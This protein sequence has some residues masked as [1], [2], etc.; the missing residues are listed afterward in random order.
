MAD[1][2]AGGA[3]VPSSSYAISPSSLSFDGEAPSSHVINFTGVTL[4]ASSNL[5]RGTSIAPTRAS[6]W[7]SFSGTVTATPAQVYTDYRE[8]HT[9]GAAEV[10]GIGSFPFMD[11]GASCKS[12]FA[13]QAI[14]QVDAGSTVLSAAGDPAIGIFPIW[15]KLLLNGETFTSGGVAA[16]AFLSV[17]A[18]VTDVSGEN[19]SVFNIEQASGVIKDIFYFRATS[20]SW[21]NFFTFAAEQ[22]PI[23]AW[24]ADNDPKDS[25]PDKG[26]RVKVGAVEYQIPLYINT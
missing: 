18:N 10:L 22:A 5:I 9:A 19:V 20:G 1:N 17:Q 8:L 16:A 26:L 23:I 15:A 24:G 3:F 21:T 25:T 2:T 13:L 4:A 12:M 7:I 11:S 6:G 14:C